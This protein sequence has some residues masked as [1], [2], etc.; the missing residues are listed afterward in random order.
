MSNS[1]VASVVRYRSGT[2]IPGLAAY[3]DDG[4]R[5]KYRCSWAHR[6]A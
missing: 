5:G 1:V 6:P 2:G 3:P 4:E